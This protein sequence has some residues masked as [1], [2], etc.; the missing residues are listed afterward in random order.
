MAFRVNLRSRVIIAYTVTE[1][2]CSSKEVDRMKKQYDV[3]QN[4]S[5]AVKV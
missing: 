2:R 1:E 4:V 3:L 5:D